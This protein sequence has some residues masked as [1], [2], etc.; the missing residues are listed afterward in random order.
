M[1][2]PNLDYDVDAMLEELGSLKQ[3]W[4]LE[5]KC[6]K[7]DQIRRALTKT[8][9]LSK[10]T[11]MSKNKIKKRKGKRGGS[12]DVENLMEGKRVKSKQ[13]LPE[14]TPPPEPAAGMETNIDKIFEVEEKSMLADCISSLNAGWSKSMV[15]VTLNPS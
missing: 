2:E 1:F 5:G 14:F 4:L 7:V 3:K 15:N 10:S 13:H 12:L 6:G 8:I 9:E 11:A